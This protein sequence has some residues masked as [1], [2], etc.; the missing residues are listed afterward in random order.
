M[1]AGQRPHGRDH[2]AVILEVV[3]GVGDVVLSSVGVLGG[4]RDPAVL[5]VHLVGGGRTVQPATVGEAAP[6]GVDLRE[7]GVVAPVA[8][9]DELQQAR[10]VG[11]RLGSENPCGGT[12]LVTMFGK[13][14]LRVGPDVVFAGGLVEVC[15]ELHRVVE[16]GDDV[17]ERV[18][19]EA[20]DAHR[21]VDAG[22]A[23][24]GQRDRLQA[25][26]PSRRVV[27]D[28]PDTEQRQHFGDV[29]AR[30]AHGRGAPH[31]QPDRL[32][33]ATIV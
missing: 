2:A 21:H 24:F 32:R 9:V 17:R 26:H 31:R 7:V 12:P 16:H 13:V 15:D 14:G 11:A 5:P 3:V 29:V 19:E 10:T 28:R 25:H 23:E 1:T 33:P 18:A 6:C 8:A 4:H 20:G 27:P 30:C 22:P